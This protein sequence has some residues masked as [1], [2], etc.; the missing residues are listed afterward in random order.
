MTP[1]LRFPELLLAIA[2]LAGCAEPEPAPDPDPGPRLCNGHEALCARPFDE[3][4]LPGTH[5]SMANAEDGWIAPNQNVPI[6]AQLAS[7]IRG[8]LLDTYEE[9]GEL[10]LCHGYCELGSKPLVEALVELRTFLVEHPHEVIAIIFQDGISPQQTEAAFVDAGL[11]DHVL[12][13]GEAWPTLDELI[14]ADTRVLVTAEF[15]GGPP[16]W[17]AHAWDL[18][19]DT[20]YSFREV[21]DMDCEPNRGDPGNPLFLV[22]HWLSAPLPQADEAPHTNSAAVLRARIE[23]CEQ[24][25]GR[26]PT[27]LAVDFHDVGDVLTVVAELN[28]R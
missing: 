7:G 17:H 19:W 27:L 21:A 25:H 10:L 15:S 20:D 22:N 5:N 6:A 4:V 14:D 8:L 9:D 18:F 2:V 1:S 11:I 3:V 23:Q 24:Q 12:V 13:P 28:E 26:L 16:D